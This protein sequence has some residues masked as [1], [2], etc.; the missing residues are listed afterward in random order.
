[1]EA[2]GEIPIVTIGVDPELLRLVGS[3]A[4]PR[5]N[6]TGFT[7]MGRE[8]TAKRLEVLLSALPNI[9]AVAVLLNPANPATNAYWQTTEEAARSFGLLSVARV[10]AE[11]IKALLALRPTAFTGAS[12][13]VVM[14]DGLFW[15]HRRDVLALVNSAQL[16]AVYAEREYADDGGLIAHGPNISDNFRRAA[17][18]VDRI[19]KAPNPATCRSRSRSSSISSSTSRLRR[20]SA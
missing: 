9:A 2:T 14:Q 1:M 16:P 12:A 19:L 13:V 15:N 6:V 8:L 17:S 10:E 7:N 3:L 11:S 5:V 4:R 18:Y 20:N